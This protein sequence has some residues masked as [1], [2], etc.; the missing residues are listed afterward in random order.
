M[1]DF[2]LIERQKSGEWPSVTE[3][4]EIRITP[5]WRKFIGFALDG[6]SGPQAGVSSSQEFHS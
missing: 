1:F 3:K 2:G 6:P 4:D 5:L